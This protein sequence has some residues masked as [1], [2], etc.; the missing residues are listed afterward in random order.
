MNINYFFKYFI[1][2]ISILIIIYFSIYIYN[3]YSV[4]D[5]LL[6]IPDNTITNSQN[7]KE[8]LKPN[9]IGDSIGGILNPLIG[10]VAAI[11]T[12]LAFLMQVFANDEIKK[13]FTQDK[14]ENRIFKLMDMYKDNTSKLHFKSKQSGRELK[15]KAVF[16]SLYIHFQKLI[17][18]V[19]EYH[20]N[21]NLNFED[22][23]INYYKD[24]LLKK[25]ENCNLENWIK[26][27]FCYILFFFGVGRKGRENVKLYL[28]NKYKLEY[29]E[30][31][32][33]Y[34]SYKPA[35]VSKDYVHFQNWKNIFSLLQQFDDPCNI[36]FNKYYEGIQ[37]NFG[38]YYRNL[39]STMNYINDGKGFNY[40][41]KWHFAKLFRTQMS[42]HEQIFFF[43]N[44]ISVLG[45]DWELNTLIKKEN[46]REENKRI[47]TKYDLIK[48]IPIADR[49]LLKVQEFYPN[50]EYENGEEETEYRKLLNKKIYK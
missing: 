34:L 20:H 41:D 37:N 32:I 15:G 24:E 35:F 18:E 11:F 1:P 8:K 22:Q 26:L 9:E 25:N 13:Q 2:L 33:N 21:Y 5:I 42:N 44:S 45:R 12:F 23:I 19:N 46:I 38:H 49:E 14:F 43:L 39:F 3:Y 31:I 50:I 16:P 28:K 47:I 40:N 30:Q 36:K 29:V 6:H 17:D 7:I 4:N 10:L 27:E 48:N